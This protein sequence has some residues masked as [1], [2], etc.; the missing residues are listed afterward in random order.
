MADKI[1]RFMPN[2]S[3]EHISQWDDGKWAAIHSAC[4]AWKKTDYVGFGQSTA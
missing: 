1:A 3:E 4:S 2:D